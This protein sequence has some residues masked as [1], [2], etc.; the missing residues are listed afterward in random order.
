MK[1]L[2]FVALLIVSISSLSQTPVRDAILLRKYSTQVGNKTEIEIN[3]ES[4]PTILRVFHYYVD[5][6]FSNL[7]IEINGKNPFISISGTTH[8]E[9]NAAPEK[10]L[11]GQALRPD[12]AGLNVTTVAD[13]LAKFLVERTKQ[14][15]SITF[16]EKFKTFLDSP[17]AEDF[18]TLFPSTKKVL[19]AVDREIYQYANYLN[20]L[21]E[22]FDKD[23][24]ALMNNL[25]PV[26]DRRMTSPAAEYALLSLDVISK[27]KAG[28]HPAE[29][30]DHLSTR[31]V[32]DDLQAFQEALKVFAIVSSSIRS[33]NPDRYWVSTDSLGLLLNDRNTLRIYLG[34]IY[35]QHGD[36]EIN[37]KKLKVYLDEVAAAYA[38]NEEAIRN[39][40]QE[41]AFKLQAIDQ[42]LREAKQIKKS[43]EKVGSYIDLFTS[44]IQ[45]LEAANKVNDLKLLGITVGETSKGKFIAILNHAAELAADLN[46]RKF[47]AAI[48]DLSALLTEA[49][50]SAPTWNDELIRYGTFM[51]NVA[52]AQNSNE[53]QAAIE[54]VA[55]PVGSASI[56]RKSARNISLN[57]YVGLAG[58]YEYNSSTDEW[59]GTFGINT[60][61]GIAFS[62]GHYKEQKACFKERGSSTLFVSLV[63]IGAFSTYRFNDS[64]TE[65][66]PDV[67][68]AN[69]FAPGL[70]YVYGFPKT[71][72]SLGVGGQL[73][74]QLRELTTTAATNNGFNG[75]LRIFLAMDIPLINFFT[76]SR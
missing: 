8:T 28:I 30:L 20:L 7:E 67:T 15:L 25:P 22:A 1:F 72:V 39:L 43:G 54:A 36:V 63:D 38:K 70:Y 13:G 24:R 16:F 21:R 3:N 2:I 61:V 19:D 26:I 60:P 49:L 66:L 42:A 64:Q 73:G 11:I 53:V 76:K 9:A 41:I 71:P 51:A 35:A 52:Q 17:E 23:L 5:H 46:E 44:T 65:E 6:D 58:G 50:G 31:Q 68:L 10:S 18:R 56:K 47:N 40:I 45:L 12:V 27:L 48:V 32:P 57:A 34:L 29:I 4:R 59:K 74:P 62:R 33:G 75:S 14:E 69:I 55:L 37:K